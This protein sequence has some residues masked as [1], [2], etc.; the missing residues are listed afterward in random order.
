MTTYRLYPGDPFGWRLENDRLIVGGTILDLRGQRT[1]TLPLPDKAV[2]V[3]ILPGGVGALVRP[4]GQLGVYALTDGSGAI[5]RQVT[6][7]ICSDP[8]GKHDRTR[9]S[10]CTDQVVEFFGWRGPDQILVKQLGEGPQRQWLYPLDAV[11]LGT[12]QRR[13]VYR[14][15]RVPG[16]GSMV[17]MSADRLSRKLQEKL[18]F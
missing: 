2:P 6:L 4:E 14:D 10:Q 12:G 17:I 5:T 9:N 3:S 7:P 18:A 8:N 11:Y 1:G 16:T 13:P 15:E